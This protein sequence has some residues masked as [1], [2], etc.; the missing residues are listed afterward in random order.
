M[1]RVFF[2]ATEDALKNIT[3]QFKLVHPLRTSMLYT[4]KAVAQIIAE[5]QTADN[6]YLKAV[7][8]PD[9]NVHGTGYKDAFL[10]TP[11]EEQEEQLAWLLLN[12]LFAVHEGWAESLFLERFDGK[13]YQKEA[14]VKILEKKNLSSKFTSYYATNPK[15]SKLF[16][17]TFFDV[18]KDTSKLDFSKLDNYMLMYRYFKEMRNAFMHGNCIAS[19]RVIDAYNDYSA[20]AT[21][22][23]LDVTEVPS[24]IQPILGQKVHLNIRGV[25]G[26]S[27][28]VQRILIISDINLI[29]TKA[30]EDEF[31]SRRSL[32]TLPTLNHNSIRAK[33]QITSICG[34][35]G[36]LKPIWSEGFQQYLIAHRFICR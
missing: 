27:D 28:F 35:A 11:W 23:D 12:N 22:T 30:A 26:F 2:R 31:L 21:T 8:D 36:F 34:Q 15:K 3:E 29:Q 18:Y 5:N 4:R 19:Q 6:A 20:V 14:F 10:N 24:I 16:T 17:D 7:I 1:A 33:E 9:D 25:I 32:Q 13:G